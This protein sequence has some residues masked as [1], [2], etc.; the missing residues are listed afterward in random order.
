MYTAVE[1]WSETN[2]TYKPYCCL[3][4]QGLM[5]YQNIKECLNNILHQ[6][7]EY[8]TYHPII[9]YKYTSVLCIHKQN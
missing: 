4:N 5:A 2:E 6:M 3:E 9:N 1:S 8:D 7:V